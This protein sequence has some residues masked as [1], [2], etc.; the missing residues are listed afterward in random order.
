MLKFEK[1]LSEEFSPDQKYVFETRGTVTMKQYSQPFSDA[2]DKKLNG[3]VER[4]LRKSI[5][6]VGSFWY[7]AWVDAGQPDLTSLLNQKVSEK[8]KEEIEELNKKYEAGKI[9]GRDHE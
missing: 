9:H 2:Y 1:E 8:F 3:M 4:K 7:T 6:A 5:I